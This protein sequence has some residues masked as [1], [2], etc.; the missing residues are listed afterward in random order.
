MVR[1]ASCAMGHPVL[2]RLWRRA[3][4]PEMALVRRQRR[5]L[6]TIRAKVVDTACWVCVRPAVAVAVLAGEVGT[7]R[8]SFPA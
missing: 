5:E 8:G 7:L 4:L 3:A 6:A 2:T 1:T